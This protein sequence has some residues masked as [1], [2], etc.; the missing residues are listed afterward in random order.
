MLPN[1]YSL[2]NTHKRGDLVTLHGHLNLHPGR[3]VQLRLHFPGGGPTS[4]FY[5]LDPETKSFFKE[6]QSLVVI[7][8]FQTYIHLLLDEVKFQ[9][10]IYRQ[11]TTARQSV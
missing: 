4:S 7:A 11:I 9:S 10:S 2:L 8:S 1:K 5:P 3:L 6:H